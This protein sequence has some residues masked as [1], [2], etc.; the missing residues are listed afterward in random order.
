MSDMISIGVTGHRILGDPNAVSRAVERVLNVILEAFG[1]QEMQVISPLAEGADRIVAWRAIEKYQAK[2]IVPLPLDLKDYMSDFVTKF[3]LASFVTL[4]ESAHDVISL[5]P[6]PTREEGYLAAGRYVLE[7]CD[8]LIAV[9]DGEP[10]RGIG[11]T[12]QM[13][14]EARERGLPLAWIQVPTDGKEMPLHLDEIS[15]AVPVVYERF[16]RLPGEQMD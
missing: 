3:S 10:P 15:K 11:G 12:A 1:D 2:L 13:V 7:H 4:L 5:P 14:A 16:P 8:V 6:Q 9:W